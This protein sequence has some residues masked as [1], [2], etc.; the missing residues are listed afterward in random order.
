M[1][2]SRRPKGTGSITYRKES[3]L[4]VGS[5][6]D[7]GKRRYV[8]SRTFCGM[9]EKFRD[10]KKSV[11]AQ[12]AREQGCHSRSECVNLVRRQQGICAYCGELALPPEQD[13]IVPFSRG[14]SDSIDNIAVACV[15]C[16]AAKGER[17]A[18]EFRSDVAAGLITEQ[19]RRDMPDGDTI[20]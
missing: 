13:R 1:K 18:E 14:G 8:S 10:L 20:S 9:S 5:V 4:W 11:A 6:V 2:R 17:T 7:H 12:N 3:G 15:E 19:Q 16:V